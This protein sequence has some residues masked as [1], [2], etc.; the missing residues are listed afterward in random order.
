MRAF[1]SYSH[2]DE[3]ALERLHIH[4][5]NL[6]REGLIETW[7]DRDILAGGGFD[8][9]IAEQL[10]EASLFLLLVSPDF[11]HSNYCYEI[12]MTKALGRHEAG[13][14]RVVPIIIEPCEWKQTPLGKLKAVPRDGKPVSEWT[15][16]NN[17]FLDV[18]QE[19]RRVVTSERPASR[20]AA[21][22][23]ALP[24]HEQPTTAR[25][26]RVTREFD[27]I[28]RAEFREKSF[29]Q[30][31]DYFRSAIQELEGIEDLRGRFVDYSP[32]SFG[33]TV[34]NRARSSRSTAHITVHRRSGGRGMGD[35]YWSF[36][37]NAETNTA[38]GGFSVDN[39]EYELYLTDGSYGF[40]Q[41]KERMSP[42]EAA[43]TL[44]TEFLE[45]AGVS[46]DN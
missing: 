28:D 40:Q 18:T 2:R 43:E 36:S 5:A 45:Q 13:D 17:A 6:K 9:E 25:R 29:E 14:A 11:L 19:L 3:A 35:I 22:A 27:E 24:S 7:Y 1:I 38:Q 4:L 33:G 31:K 12:E 23:R 39:D 20:Q 46:Y 34:V 26:Y 37:E 30:I 42:A 21:S 41:R 44:W 16:A 15:N 10:E 8:A 32:T